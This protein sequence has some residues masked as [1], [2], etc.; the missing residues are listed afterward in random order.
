M[1]VVQF[2]KE[3]FIALNFFRAV[4]LYPELILSIGIILFSGISHN[5][6]SPMPVFFFLHHLD[7]FLRGEFF[8]IPDDLP[9]FDVF[10]MS[11]DNQMQM[12][13]HKNKA[14]KS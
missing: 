11:A 2:L 13:G 7:Y 10:V 12:V 8:E 1:D 6:E 4:V 5:V 3:E 9:E 14:I